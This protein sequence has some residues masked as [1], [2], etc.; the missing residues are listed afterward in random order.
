LTLVSNEFGSEATFGF[1]LQLG[2]PS[3]LLVDDDNG[4][5]EQEAYEM[6]LFNRRTPFDAY[7]KSVSGSPSGAFLNQYET[8]IWMIGDARSDIL[9]AADVSAMQTFLD[10]SGN[11]FLSGQSIV[12][13][14]DTDDQPFLNNYLRASY[15][16]DLLYPFIIG[17]NGTAIGNG[18]KVRLD[19]SSNQT[20][21]QRMATNAFRPHNGVLR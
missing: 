20:N 10:S 9:S 11:L 6:A 4:D 18:I 17:Q 13:E 16:N 5:S 7:D 8:V 3:I 15:T 2:A 12:K 14:L 19:G 21:P 1:E